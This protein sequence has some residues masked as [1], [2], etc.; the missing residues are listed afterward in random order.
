LMSRAAGATFAAIAPAN[1]TRV[2]ALTP[3][4]DLSVLAER[5][6]AEPGARRTAAAGVALVHLGLPKG[7]M[8]DNVLRPLADAGLRL[9]FGR[10]GYRPSI[11]L[12]GFEAKILKPQNIAEMLH[13]GSR[14]VGFAGADWVAELEAEVVE[15]LDTGLDPVRVVAAAPPAFANTWRK[16]NG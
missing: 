11:S 5:A 3:P 15:L 13:L 10:R 4:D 8:H 6:A 14:D 1:L 7:R 16:R 2:A 9:T 12:P